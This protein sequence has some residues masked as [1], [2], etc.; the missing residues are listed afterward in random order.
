MVSI[1]T[2]FYYQTSVPEFDQMKMI[3][4]SVRFV[5]TLGLL[6]VAFKGKN[7]ARIILVILLSVGALSSCAM[8]FTL[9]APFILRLP[10]IVMLIVYGVGVYH[11]GLSDSYK[12][13]AAY[14]NEDE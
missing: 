3:Q 9:S 7:W 8:V 10:F 12:A 4:Q 13:F 5:L 14:Q 2:I 1:H 6:Y 11:F